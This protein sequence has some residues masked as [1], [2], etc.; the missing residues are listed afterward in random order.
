MFLEMG[1]YRSRIEFEPL[2]TPGSEH[3][4]LTATSIK[5]TMIGNTISGISDQWRDVFSICR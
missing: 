4:W 1:V 3:S 5:E 2:G